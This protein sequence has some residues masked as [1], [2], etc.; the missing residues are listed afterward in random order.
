MSAPDWE[1]FGRAIMD[2]WQEHC[3]VDAGEKFDLAVNHGIVCEIPG[4]YDPDHHVDAYGCAEKGDPWY[5]TNTEADALRAE[6][7]R[8]KGALGDI[9]DGEPEFQDDPQAELDW[10]RERAR[11]ALE[12]TKP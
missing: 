8:L 7:K 11:A 1:G 6:N 2:D 3:D 9:W 4:G 5:E 10:C 12:E